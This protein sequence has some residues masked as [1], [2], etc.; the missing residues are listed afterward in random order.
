MREI[1]IERHHGNKPN[2]LD[3][4]ANEH[5]EHRIKRYKKRKSTF[6]NYGEQESVQFVI[7]K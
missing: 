7:K 2:R 3:K 1:C 6:Y 4:W 5:S